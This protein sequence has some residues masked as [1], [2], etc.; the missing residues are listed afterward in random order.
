M[1]PSTPAIETAFNL[2]IG[3][4]IAASIG[5]LF[6]SFA[7]SAKGQSAIWKTV[8]GVFLCLL[9]FELSGTNRGL[10]LVVQKALGRLVDTVQTKLPEANNSKS[11]DGKSGDGN[12][13]DFDSLPT[14]A[15]TDF[16]PWLTT[17]L[18]T[19]IGPLGWNR[20]Q[21]ISRE[22]PTAVRSRRTRAILRIR[23]CCIRPNNRVGHAARRTARAGPSG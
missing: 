10:N 11:I 1:L 2:L 6:A 21:C 8:S 7:R 15:A 16:D 3:S 20:I 22:T 19:P 13:K 9:I 5:L 4:T 14:K 18:S 17:S 12:V 23:I